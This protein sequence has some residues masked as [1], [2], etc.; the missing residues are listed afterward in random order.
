[1]KKYRDLSLLPFFIGLIIIIAFYFFIG[2]KLDSYVDPAEQ[3]YRDGYEDGLSDGSAYAE[4][5]ID[6][7]RAR[8]LDALEIIGSTDSYEGEKS[9]DEVCDEIMDD[10][11]DALAWLEKI[12]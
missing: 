7:A 12:E 11:H 5:Y 2:K 4:D 8:L 1:M 3:A 6:L 9:F 10:I